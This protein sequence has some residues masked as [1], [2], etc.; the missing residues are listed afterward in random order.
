MTLSPRELSAKDLPSRS[1]IN[2]RLT[3]THGYG[4]VVSPVNRVTREGLPEFWVKDIPR[5]PPP[6]SGSPVRSS[7]S[8]SSPLSMSS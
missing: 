7:T 2:E 5:Q 1:W 6:T 8:A 3:Y 4:A